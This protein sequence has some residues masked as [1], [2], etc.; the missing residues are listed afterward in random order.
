MTIHEDDFVD[1]E[2]LRRSE[3][4]VPDC[5]KVVEIPYTQYE[6][7]ND[8]YKILRKFFERKY[9]PK[10]PFVSRRS[11]ETAWERCK[12]FPNEY[13]DFHCFS[14]RITIWRESG[15]QH[16]YAVATFGYIPKSEHFVYHRGYNGKF[17]YFNLS[18]D[19]ENVIADWYLLV[20]EWLATEVG[21]KIERSGR[22]LALDFEPVS[23]P[24]SIRV[25]VG[26]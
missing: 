18:E 16:N 8:F 9:E 12:L 26:R 6:Q 14:V 7:L 19:L 5:E 10:A 4:E 22:N 11:A 2:R 15:N 13:Y 3:K 25:S 24:D 20:S 21:V 23:E 1:I 17:M